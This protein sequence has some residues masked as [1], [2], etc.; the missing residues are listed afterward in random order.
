VERPV[1]G[2]VCENC[3]FFIRVEDSEMSNLKDLQYFSSIISN[4][5]LYFKTSK[6]IRFL[7]LSLSKARGWVSA[8][9]KTIRRFELSFE[10]A[11]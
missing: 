1:I 9:L 5:L 6:V 8:E 7:T 3:P 11:S 4:F 10:L 2:V